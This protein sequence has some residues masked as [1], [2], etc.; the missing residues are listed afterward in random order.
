MHTAHRTLA[1]AAGLVGLLLPAS[2][3]AGPSPGAPPNTSEPTVEEL[4]RAAVR[5][6]E[7]EPERVRS[8]ERR[9]RLA[10]LAPT[11]RVQ[12]GRGVFD[13]AS[14]TDAS[15]VTRLTVGAR[16]EWQFQIAATWALDRLVF[17][18]DELRLAREAQRVAARRERLVTDVAQLYYERRRL[19]LALA[20]APPPDGSAAG[21]RLRLEELSAILDGLTGGALGQRGG[22]RR[23]GGRPP[24]GGAQPVERE[25]ATEHAP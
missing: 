6:A 15:G 25:P 13:L 12:V 9:L 23:D 8:W 18:P 14:T 7:L 1:L 2:A 19:Q 4:Q 16:D 3:Q 5:H 21:V 10:P 24:E 11:L 17:H 22:D 20:Q